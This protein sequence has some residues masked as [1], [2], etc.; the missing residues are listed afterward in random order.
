M[1]ATS[2]IRAASAAARPGAST[3]PV[4]LMSPPTVHLPAS[5]PPVTVI[6]LAF[7]P[8]TDSLPALTVLAPVHVFSPVRNSVPAPLLVRLPAYT[9]GLRAASRRVPI[10]KSDLSMSDAS[11]GSPLVQPLSIL[12]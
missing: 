6:G 3:P 2:V 1:I 9:R 7:E 10:A 8:L 11:G 12:V 4:T 5:V